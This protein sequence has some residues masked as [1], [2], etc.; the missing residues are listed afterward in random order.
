MRNIKTGLKPYMYFTDVV[1]DV[2][3]KSAESEPEYAAAFL[4]SDSIS[5]SDYSRNTTTWD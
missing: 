5:D 2:L 4:S 3:L 1:P